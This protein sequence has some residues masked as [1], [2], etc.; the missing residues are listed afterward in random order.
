MLSG[1]GL[2]AVRAVGEQEPDPAAVRRHLREGDR[3]DGARPRR[4]RGRRATGKT[5]EHRPGGD[6]RC[7]ELFMF[8]TI[9]EKVGPNLTIKNWQKTVEQVRQDRPAAPTSSR[10]SARASTPPRTASAWWRSTRA[11]AT[12][13]DWKALT[14]VKD[15]SGGQVHQAGEADAAARPRTTRRRDY[16]ARCCAGSPARRCRGTTTTTRG[17]SRISL[18]QA[19]GDHPTGLEAV[20]PAADRQDQRE[21]VLDHDQRGVE[22][23]LHPQDQR[24]ERLG[25]ALGHAGGRLVEADDPW[26]DREHGGELDDAP[27]PGRELGDVAVG[28]A[29]EAEEVDELSGLGVLRALRPDRRQPRAASPRTTSRRAP[30]AR[31]APCRAR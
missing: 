23:L 16:P 1:T 2:D 11:S 14:P 15:A 24:T 31:A 29:T 19:L 12:S 20:D 26:R 8:K 5:V 27:G 22:L 7:G 4:A 28:V 25:L 17:S 6:R 13:G 3:H 9:A 10:R 30:R 18:G 21:V